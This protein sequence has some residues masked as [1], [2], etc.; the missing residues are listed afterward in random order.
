VTCTKTVSKNDLFLNCRRKMKELSKKELSNVA[1]A[2]TGRAVTVTVN[3]NCKLF[4]V[5]VNCSP[6]LP[7]SIKVM[8]GAGEGRLWPHKDRGDSQWLRPGSR[9]RS[10]PRRWRG[11]T[12]WRSP[13]GCHTISQ[14]CSGTLATGRT[15]LRLIVIAE[16]LDPGLNQW[17][18]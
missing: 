5:T 2:S 13:P 7:Q 17:F 10:W 6:W 8:G 11:S 12:R 16:T 18:R 14:T 3:W 1:P 4:T 9:T 15:T